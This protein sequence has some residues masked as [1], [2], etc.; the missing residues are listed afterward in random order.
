MTTRFTGKV[1][2][3]TG[4]GSGIGQATAQA[5]AREGATVVV[6]GRSPQSLA[7]TVKLIQAEGGR[8]TAITADVTRPEDVAH[9]V[10]ATV[11]EH[12][13]LHLAFNNAGVI[14][15]GPVAD[16]DQDTWDRTLAVNLT[17]VWLSMKYEIAHMRAHGGG[18]IVNTASNVGASMRIPGLGAYAAA[19]AGVSALT[20]TAAREYIGDGIRIN[21]ISPGPLDTPMS[22]RPGE[23][24]VDRSERIK[25]ALPIGRVGSLEE[26]AA[27]V[28]WLASPDAGFVVGHDLVLDG[29][30]SA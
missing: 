20:R 2:L 24:D 26:V 15:A 1:A 29:G 13:G 28:L 12:G 8:A 19:K 27:T 17:G 30:A 23:T 22:L 10:A 3:V 18:V 9:L 11:A 16:L 25:D 4:G 5:F 6:A 21:A 7:Q 14:G